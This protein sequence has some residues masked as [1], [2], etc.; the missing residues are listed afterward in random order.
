VP[1][2]LPCRS[3]LNSLLIAGICIAPPAHADDN[4]VA[5][6]R[7]TVREMAEWL[8]RGVDSW[9]GDKPFEEGGKVSDGVLS[10]SLLKREHETPDFSV[11]FNARFSLPNIEESSYLFIGRD[12]LRDVVSDQPEALGR[13]Q[14]LLRESSVEPQFFAGFGVRARDSV[15][16]RIGFRGGLKPYLQVRYKHVFQLDD[17]RLV[18]FLQ[19]LHWT[20]DDRIGSTT[21]VSY[22]HDFSPTLSG[23]WLSA[24]T[25]TERVRKFEWSSN[26]GAYKSFGEQRLWSLELLT[27]GVQGSGIGVSD[28]GV[29]TKWEQPIHE[30]WLLGELLVGHFWPRLDVASERGRAWAV[31]ARLKMKF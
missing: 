31:G 27:N 5:S 16:A 21:A 10:L 18:D 2:C 3:V 15:D 6:A 29:Q 9:F 1:T 25:I 28:Y 7:Q 12:D 24:A 14:R 22:E 19:T 26:L 4:V 20:R 13:Q 8:A 11:R 30:D 23:R 17:D